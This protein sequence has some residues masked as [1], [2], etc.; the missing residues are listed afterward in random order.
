[1][2]VN[3]EHEDTN[4]VTINGKSQPI[5]IKQISNWLMMTVTSTKQISS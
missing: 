3:I 1:M 4:D 5:T 2:D